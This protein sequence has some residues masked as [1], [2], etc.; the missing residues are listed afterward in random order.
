MHFKCWYSVIL[1]FLLVVNSSHNLIDSQ[2]DW[3]YFWT[4]EWRQATQNSGTIQKPGQLTYYVNLWWW[5]VVSVFWSLIVLWCWQVYYIYIYLNIKASN[6]IYFYGYFCSPWCLT[7][8]I[9][10]LNFFPWGL[11]GVQDPRKLVQYH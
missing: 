10:Y 8:N 5:T 6:Q 2:F 1:L 4:F 7:I 11:S 3:I 9:M